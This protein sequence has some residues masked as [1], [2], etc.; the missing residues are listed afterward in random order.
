MARGPPGETPVTAGGDHPALRD[1]RHAN[2]PVEAGH[3]RLKARLP[4]APPGIQGPGARAIG[5]RRCIPEFYSWTIREGIA[6]QCQLH[7]RKLDV[8]GSRLK[9]C[10][11]LGYFGGMP[12]LAS[13]KMVAHQRACGNI[14]GWKC[15]ESNSWLILSAVVPRMR[16]A[17]A[18]SA[19]DSGARPGRRG[20]ARPSLALLGELE[21]LAATATQGGSARDLA[22]EQRRRRVSSWRSSPRDLCANVT[23]RAGLT[24]RPAA[25]NKSS[26]SS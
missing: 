6:Q 19:R 20:K 21:G 12:C 17:A 8:L 2:N 22:L 25:L 23:G 13:G 18:G 3:G 10:V 5:T 24:A 15:S 9:C 16:R 14:P 11:I 7:Q 26:A 4:Q 1:Q